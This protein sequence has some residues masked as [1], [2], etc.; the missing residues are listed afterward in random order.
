MTNYTLKPIKALMLVSNS[1]FVAPIYLEEWSVTALLSVIDPQRMLVKSAITM[2]GAVARVTV[3]SRQHMTIVLTNE[4]AHRKEPAAQP[5]IVCAAVRSTKSET[6]H[7][8]PRHFDVIGAASIQNSTNPLD[9]EQEVEWE[10]G[11]LDQFGIFYNR[12]VAWMV[13]VNANQIVRRCGG[14]EANGGTLYSENLY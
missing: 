13:A 8:S 4:R 9:L 12:Q 14:D 11:F 1:S 5:V 3:G 7:A 10:E 6:I 2:D